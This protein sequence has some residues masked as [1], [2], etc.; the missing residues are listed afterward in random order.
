MLPA[1]FPAQLP[2]AWRQH[3]AVRFHVDRK[4]LVV[5]VDGQPLGIV[6][7]DELSIF[8]RL[9]IKLSQTG[10]ENL[11]AHAFHRMVPLDIEEFGEGGVGAVLQNVH[12]HAIVT[13]IGHV[14]RNDILNP[15][16]V[17]AV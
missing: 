2:Y 10:S 4:S 5:I 11:A 3:L 14:V 17:L 16:H 6:F 15:A 8:Q 7:Q 1:Q 13:I 9:A 12:Q